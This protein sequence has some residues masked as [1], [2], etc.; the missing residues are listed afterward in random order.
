M[1]AAQRDRNSIFL[2]RVPMSP[3]SESPES[4]TNSP[5]GE[6]Q[7]NPACIICD[8]H[9]WTATYDNLVT[10][11]R[12]CY[13]RAAILPSDAELAQLYD[14]SYFQGREYGDY[15]ADL[16]VHRRNF[17]RRWRE[18]VQAM[19]RAPRSVFE[20]GCAYGL[21]LSVVK[22]HGVTAAGIDL[23]ADAV[24]WARTHGQ[25]Q[26]QTGAYTDLPLVP[27][28]AELICLWDTIEHLRH[29]E[30]FIE[31]I[32]AE[33]PE[34]GCVVI[35]T[36]DIGSR[37][38]RRRGR[39]WRM[40][41]PPTHLH[42]FSRDSLSSLLRRYGLQTFL[43]KSCPIYRDLHSVLGALAALHRGPLQ[44][45]A[46]WAHRLLPVS[47]QRFVGGWVDL[48][49]IQ[50]LIAQRPVG[51]HSQRDAHTVLSGEAPT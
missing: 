16:P 42:Y 9:Q 10:C 37:L 33:L 36:G 32:A 49:D 20:I 14:A 50:F 22:E 18:L 27:N 19:G 47:L 38:A 44:R 12:C 34:G 8:A 7:E 39:H 13:I 2:Q 51:E 26:A 29:P 40:I 31:K 35:T 41:H 3:S 43:V 17:Q 21:W 11:E 46:R 1:R 25:V 5:L 6:S 45:L 24:E 4:R 15:L 48:G 30:Q 28:R 23:S